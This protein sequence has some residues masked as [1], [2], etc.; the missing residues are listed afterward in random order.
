MPSIAAS[1][2][3]ASGRLDTLPDLTRAVRDALTSDQ[4]RLIEI[5]QRRLAST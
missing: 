2:G 1:Y 3:I 4:P 5:T